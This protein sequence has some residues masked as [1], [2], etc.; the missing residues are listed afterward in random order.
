MREQ[1]LVPR[2]VKLLAIIA[3]VAVGAVIV[4]LITNRSQ[5]QPETAQSTT[6]AD[7]MSATQTAPAPAEAKDA[8]VSP[9]AEIDSDVDTAATQAPAPEPTTAASD[10]DEVVSI[11]EFFRLLV[12]AGWVSEET[13]PGVSFVMANNEQA[14]ARFHNNS[15]VEPGDAVIHVGFLPYRLLQTN[16][17]RSLEFAY[18]ASPDVFLQSLLPLFRPAG[19]A[20]LSDGVELV[21]LDSENEAG[22][23]TVSGAGSEGLVLMFSAGDSVIGLVSAINAPGET[24]AYQDTAYAVAAGVEFSG[25][26]D[27]LYGTLLGG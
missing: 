20:M 16:E 26:Q 22:K 27:A 14:L 1:S 3:L 17:L 23:L 24:T 6:G 21:S 12:P 2:P 18:D 15:A 8:T 5:E 19:E 25:A 9:T 7:T 11:T 13:K 4:L 10:M